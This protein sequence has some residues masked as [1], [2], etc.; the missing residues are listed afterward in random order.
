[1][2]SC[3]II[4]IIITNF[5]HT[6]IL[7]KNRAQWPTHC[8]TG[9]GQT[10]SL[11]TMQNSSTNDRM[12]WKLRKLRRD[13]KSE[14]VSFQMVTE[15]TYAIW[16]LNMFGEW[17]PKSRDSSTWK[18]TSP[19]AWVLT[20]GTDNKKKQMKGSLWA[21]VMEKAWKIDMKVEYTGDMTN[22]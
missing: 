21:W 12:Q 22:M 19:R 3:L 5:Y 8:S 2:L 10:H 20:L 9:V 13:K 15:R 17:I 6:N 1:M 14:K 16:W 4:I 18:G 11:D 7:E